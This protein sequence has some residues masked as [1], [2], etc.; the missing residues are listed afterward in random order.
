M[1]LFDKLTGTRHPEDGVPP[2]PAQ[3]VR[4]ALLDLNRDDVPYVVADGASQ[5]ADLVAEWRMTEP[6]WQALFVESQL[7]RA[8]RVRMRLDEEKHEVRA[9]EEQWEV[10][11]VGNPP[12]LVASSDY[13]RGPDRTVSRHWTIERGAS[14]RHEVTETFRFDG[15]DLRNPLRDAALKCGWSWRAV[16]FGTL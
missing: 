4:A 6:A 9:L 5:E 7:S 3:E 13:S 15:A 1:G 8:V 12:R 10:T 16:V 11:R 14:G 2:R